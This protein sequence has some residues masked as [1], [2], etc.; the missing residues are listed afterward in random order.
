MLHCRQ[1]QAN[2]IKQTSNFYMSDKEQR[3][4]GE[5]ASFIREIVT[6]GNK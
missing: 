5:K 2:E 4:E 6:Q 3:R 1:Y